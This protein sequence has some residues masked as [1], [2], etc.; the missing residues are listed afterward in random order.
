M[1]FAEESVLNKSR[2]IID[3]GKKMTNVFPLLLN[4]LWI[5]YT[6]SQSRIYLLSD[7]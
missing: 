3:E 1:L 4:C 6:Y 5:Y 2:Q 7:F